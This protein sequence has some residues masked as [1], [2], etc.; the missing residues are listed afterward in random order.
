MMGVLGAVSFLTVV[1]VG[2]RGIPKEGQFGR[3]VVWFPLVGLLI[4][5]AL[6]GVDWCGRAAWDSYVAAALVIGAGILITGG[7]HLDGLMDTADAVFS[8]RDP[9][10]MLE[11]MRD[12]RVGALGVAA[13][14]SVLLAKFAAY[15]HL[16]GPEHWHV[17]AAA[18]AMG[19]LSMAVGVAVFPY[20]R[21]DGTGARFVAE[22][23]GWHIVGALLIASAISVGL[24][25]SVGAALAAA[26]FVIS[27]AIGWE[28]RRR[29]GGLT[30]DVY[31]AMNEIVELAAL[32]GM[33]A[34]IAR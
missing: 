22:T 14:A 8:R 6:A 16:A 23:R 30:G 19:R 26:V 28:A 27:L 3:A 1:P 24:F 15:G 9:A 33:G 10:G 29:F 4:G 2:A 5:L 31:G 12:S 18:P 25:G 32:L 21:A 20:A 7:L 13:G 17:I 11:V 34:L